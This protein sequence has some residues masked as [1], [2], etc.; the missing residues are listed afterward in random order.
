MIPDGFTSELEL[1]WLEEQAL[2][3]HAIVE[4]GCWIGRSTWA[5]A[6]TP[7]YVLSIDNWIGNDHSFLPTD[8]H[9]LPDGGLPKFAENMAGQIEAGK[10]I[11]L[12]M[13][14]QLAARLFPVPCFDMVFIDGDHR[15]GAVWADIT[16]WQSKLLKGALLCGH[17]YEPCWKDDVMRVV[18]ELVPDRQLVSGTSL[19]WKEMP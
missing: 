1:H 8:I 7:G 16:E 18:D 15:F 14:S 11:P 9:D 2:K 3:H 4:I 6:H 10:V 19:W 17:N 12:R 5:L 13:I